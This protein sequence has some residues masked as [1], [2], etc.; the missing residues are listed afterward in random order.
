LKIIKNRD[1]LYKKLKSIL[2][3]N[4]LILNNLNVYE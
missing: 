2:I 1:Y 3:L 4:S